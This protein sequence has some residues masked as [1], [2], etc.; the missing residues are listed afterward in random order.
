MIRFL[1]EVVATIGKIDRSSLF[2][3]PTKRSEILFKEGLINTLN[4]PMVLPKIT[5]W[6]EFVSK[7]IQPRIADKNEQLI[8]LYN[9]YVKLSKTRTSFSSFISWGS[10]L[11]SDFETICLTQNNGQEVLNKTNLLQLL[12]RWNVSE[13]NSAEYSKFW[14]LLPNLY[15]EFYK[16]IGEKSVCTNAIAYSLASHESIQNA[17]LNVNEI[18]FLG[19]TVFSEAEKSL[20]IKLKKRCKVNCYYDSPN[21]GQSDAQANYFKSDLLN[22]FGKDYF[23]EI[24]QSTSDKVFSTFQCAGKSVMVKKLAKLVSNMPHSELNKCAIVVLNDT[25]F[26]LILNSVTNSVQELNSG[27]GKPFSNTT[28][29]RWIL[30]CLQLRKFYKRYNYV[31]VS[32]WNSYL[33]LLNAVDGNINSDLEALSDFLVKNN[34]ARITKVVVEQFKPKSELV[35]WFNLLTQTQTSLSFI[36]ECV[37]VLPDMLP[38]R[39]YLHSFHL[40]KELEEGDISEEIIEFLIKSKILGQNLTFSGTKTHG[41]QVLSLLETRGI[42]FEHLIFLS[43]NEDNLPSSP[44]RTFLPFEIR[45]QFNFPSR[46]AKE[47]VLSYHFQRLLKRS[48]KV[49]LLFNTSSSGLETSEPSRF[50]NQLLFKWVKSSQIQL[51]NYV[52]T[53]NQLVEKQETFS[54]LK[55]ESVKVAI[56]SYL[57]DRGLSPSALNVYLSNPMDF[58]LYHVLG[59]REKEE[60]DTSVESHSLG[61]II[62]NVLELLYEPFVNK[63]IKDY[64]KKELLKPLEELV[65]AEI[66][67]I[68]PSFTAFN[69]KTEI[70]YPVVLNWVRNFCHYDLKF[71]QEAFLQSVESRKRKQVIGSPI[72][73]SI[74]GVV[75]RVDVINNTQHVIDYKTGKVEPKD[76][77]LT[78]EE[79]EELNPEKSKAYQLLLYALMQNAETPANT[80]CSIYSFRNQKLGYIP[81]LIDGEKLISVDLMNKFEKGLSKLVGEM[82]DSGLDIELTNHRYQKFSV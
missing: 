9:S 18:N 27:I 29:G 75:D 11:L 65:K 31:K 39:E 70:L 23:V 6:N 61:T 2:I 28:S 42:D 21:W 64:S 16:Q 19:F 72:N 50:Y 57:Q 5:N 49:D 36:K 7:L 77:K 41:L 73:F 47:S 74:K 17:S 37:K 26:P 69:A 1:S 30:K 22:F 51:N 45:N 15:E 67:N 56:Q 60:V 24:H 71:N 58:L 13:L 68:F 44:I 3:L 43:F 63:Q 59:I 53:A 8:L 54:I 48:K 4:A 76:L 55:T 79:L 25:D 14:D 82:L 52:V 34:V 62:H 32:D 38:I 46:T 80:M 33:H 20:L 78:S 40:I 10:T 81:L 66:E 12:N 35:F